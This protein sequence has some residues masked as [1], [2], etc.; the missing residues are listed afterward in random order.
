MISVSQIPYNQE[1]CFQV[2]DE[3]L[4]HLSAGLLV[5]CASWTVFPEDQ[6]S[7]YWKISIVSGHFLSLWGDKRLL[8]G[9]VCVRVKSV[10]LIYFSGGHSPSAGLHQP[11][12]GPHR[13]RLHPQVWTKIFFSKRNVLLVYLVICVNSIFASTAYS[14]KAAHHLTSCIILD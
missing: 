13:R 5:P 10:F 6:E 9:C 11:V 3:V 2:P 1:S 14:V 7:E 12:F 8:L 4:L